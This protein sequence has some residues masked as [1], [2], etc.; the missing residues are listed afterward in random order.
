MIGSYAPAVRFVST[1]GQAPAASLGTALF[2]GLAP[3]GGLYVP[4]P[5]EPWAPEELAAV[6][7]MSLAE[8]GVRVLRPFAKSIDARTLSAIV[9]DALDFD[10]PLVNVEPGIYA[11]ELFH[12]PT[13]AF[14]DVGARV[15]ARL[16]ATLGGDVTV[17]TATSGDTGSAVAHAFYGIASARVVILYPEGRVS[18]TQEAQLTMF[19]SEPRSNVRGY[20][21]SGSFDDCQR[22]VKEAFAD[23]ELRRRVPLTSANSINVGRLLPQM[24]YYFQAIAQLKRLAGDVPR[25]IVCTPSGNF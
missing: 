25:P 16:M 11:L 4:D 23:R 20:A 18:P 8:I 21:I 3:D 19:N 10:I 5:I 6:P 9:H 13:L 14:K 1:R 15:M 7:T 12:G 22:L 2:D 17:L 24:I